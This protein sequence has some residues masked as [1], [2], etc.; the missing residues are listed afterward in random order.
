MPSILPV[1]CAWLSGAELA[2]SQNINYFMKILKN[3]L[4][5]TSP[6]PRRHTAKKTDRARESIA[7]VAGSNICT[8]TLIFG[9]VEK[10]VSVHEPLMAL[11]SRVA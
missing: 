10:R 7:T 5:V 9:R 1:L 6:A 3:Y 8:L 2:I 4:I 11:S